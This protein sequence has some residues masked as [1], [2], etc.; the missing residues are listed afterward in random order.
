M[1]E[2]PTTIGSQ[3]AHFNEPEVSGKLIVLENEEYYKISNCDAM[4]PFFM[5]IVSD[6]NHWM[7]ISSNGALSAGRKDSESPL[8]PYY[9]DDKITESSAIT[10]S[11]TILRVH[12]EG[13]TKLWE[14]FSE[15]YIGI[16]NI[17]R[18]LYKNV[19]GNK[20]IFE[21]IN[22]DLELT[23]RYQWSSSDQYGF[24]KKATLINNANTAVSTTV[25]DGIHNIMPYG[26][27]T[28]LQAMSSNLVDAYKKSELEPDI[29]LGIYALSA[30]IVDRAEPSEA[31]KATTVWSWGVKNPTYLVSSLQLNSFRKGKII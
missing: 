31:L 13:R 29:G 2:Q 30:I 10:G 18:N 15:R 11:K 26:V 6:S 24:V 17:T 3:N 14:P 7:F 5:S 4:R 9:T 28:G 25:L 23:F 20:V 21:E 19:Y 8:F 22:N 12:R 16:Y 27:D 1:K